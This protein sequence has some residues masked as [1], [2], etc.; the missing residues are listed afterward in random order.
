MRRL[1]LL[2]AAVICATAAAPFDPL[3]EARIDEHPGARIPMSGMLLDET[4]A[5]TTLA[6]LGGGKP[7]LIVPVLHDC[8]NLCG[9]TL[10][11]LAGAMRGAKLA[12]GRDAAVIAFG[13]DP[14]ESVRDARL[15]LDRLAERHPELTGRIH[16]TIAS[17]P[18]I[19]AVTDALGYR[20]AFD[21]RIGQYAH[22]AAVAVLTPDGRFSRWLYGL[23][24]EPAD[25]AAAVNEAREGNTGGWARQLILLCYHYDPETG[26]Y[27][28][29]IAWLLRVACIATVLAVLAYV[30]LAKRREAVV[31]R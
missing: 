3:A 17:D 24:P 25:V 26:R 30:I 18:T 2:L 16:A 15:S 8:P 31:R 12:A 5:R 21:P 6:R 1:L 9:L 11:G 13:I 20:F 10:D 4:G 28:L 14:K 27:G 19:H 7:I 29:A 23:A 22:A